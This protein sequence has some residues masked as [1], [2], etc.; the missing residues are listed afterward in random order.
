MLTS[1]I[2]SFLV[3]TVLSVGICR[4]QFDRQMR[5]LGR[6]N[7]AYIHQM[8]DTVVRAVERLEDDAISKTAEDE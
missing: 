2:V 4:T 7:D 3:S 6:V 8:T 1:I 5:E